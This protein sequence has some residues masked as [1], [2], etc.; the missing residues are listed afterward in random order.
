MVKRT[1]AFWGIGIHS[2]F[3]SGEI[4][5]A[6]A[7]IAADVLQIKAAS[8]TDQAGMASRTASYQRRADEWMFQANL[9]ACELMQI[10]RQII[11]SLIAE[12]VAYHEYLTVKTQVQQ[13]QEV[14]TFLQ[15]S[16]QTTP[17]AG[18]VPG[19]FTTQELYGWM[20]GEVSRLYYQY[21]RFAVDAARKAERTMKQ[22]L[23]RPELD[24]TD[25]IQFNYWDSG[26]QG[27]LS[28]EALHLDVKRMEMA[29]LDNNK[30]ELELTR[31]VSLRQLDPLALLTLKVTG[32]CTVTIPEWLYD[33]DCPGHY[34]RRIKSVAISLPS[35][36]GPYTSINCTATL[37]H[38]AR[39]GSRRS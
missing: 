7:K 37:Q 29:Y 4:L 32:A 30:R 12:Q 27:L 36:V 34:L 26:R 5:G 6:L 11:G 31:H 2:K 39:Y 22:E 10:G 9:A 35:V 13:S 33:R 16:S 28:G 14:L 20:Q 17:S 24:A 25:F 15:G 23:M 38:A 19:K 8:E 3:F 21:Y 1:L 18:F